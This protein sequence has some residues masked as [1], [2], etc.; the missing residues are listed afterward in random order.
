MTALLKTGKVR[1]VG[2]SNFTVE[3]IKGII[4]ATGIVPQMNQVEAHPLLPQDDLVKY[5]GE[6]NIHLTAYSPLGNNCTCQSP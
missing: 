3:Q 6:K 2:V 5:C 1:A 4:E